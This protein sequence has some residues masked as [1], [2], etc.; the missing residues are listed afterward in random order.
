VTPDVVIV[1]AGLSGLTA[2]TELAQHGAAVALHE[3]SGSIGGRARTTEVAGYRLNLG[4]HALFPAGPAWATFRRFGLELTGG[5]VPD[6]AYRLAVDGTLVPAFGPGGLLQVGPAAESPF[7]RLMSRAAALPPEALARTSLRHLLDDALEPEP[8]GAVAAMARAATYAAADDV[9]SGDAAV[10]QLSVAGRGGSFYLDDGWQRLVEGLAQLAADS[11]VRIHRG[12]PAV[13]VV[14]RRGG[15]V[16]VETTAGLAQ[17]GGVVLAPG[18]PRRL[19]GLLSPE[20]RR[21]V[22]RVTAGARPSRLAALDLALR[23]LPDPDASVV[24]G[25]NEPL[26]LSAH[27]RWARLAPPGGTVLH[28]AHYLRPGERGG[29]DHRRRVEA[30]LDLAQPGWRDVVVDQRW[31]P[32]LEVTAVL[33][34]A[35]DGGLAGRLPVALAPHVAVAGDWVGSVGLLTDASVASALTAAHQLLTGGAGQDSLTRRT[36]GNVDEAVSSTGA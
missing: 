4:P 2:A 13:G 36:G 19:A 21:P 31:M 27:S 33:P 14:L 28:A 24:F 22:L 18:S 30:L 6:D 10:A 34:A 12:V 32:Q 26:Y 9:L 1:G 29:H 25:V 11:G 5:F 16:E 23:E 7:D 35:T 8:R 15:P 17:A 3:A 20:L